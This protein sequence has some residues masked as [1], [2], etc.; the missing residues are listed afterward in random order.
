MFEQIVIRRP[1]PESVIDAGTLAETLLFYGNIHILL[2]SSSLTA[3]VRKIGADNLI[4][5]FAQKHATATFML[6]SLATFTNTPVFGLPEHGFTAI[7]L[8]AHVG[9]KP[10]KRKDG[11]YEA[12]ARAMNDARFAKIKASQ[13]LKYIKFSE[14]RPPH[15][16]ANNVKT[17]SEQALDDLADTDYL[18][19]AVE[20]TIRQSVP[21]YQLPRGW[22]VRAIIGNGNFKLETNIN[23]EELNRAYHQFVPPEQNSITPAWLVGQ[24]HEARADLVVA[25]DYMSEIVTD[26]IRSAL[27]RKKFAQ[28]LTRREKSLAGMESFQDLQLGSTTAIRETINSGER[29]FDEFLKVLDKAARFKDWLRNVNPDAKLLEEYFKAATNNTW[30]E[31][32]PTKVTRF[33][34]CTLA[35]VALEALLASGVGY[36]AGVGL[37]AVD[38]MWTDKV[39]KGWRPSQF[40]NG[41]VKSFIDK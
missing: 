17:L 6:D 2:D 9:G 4:H 25:S 38:A 32:L 35:G 40:I 1:D 39:L 23:F 19:F 5:L 7:R 12:F 13:A 8:A 21:G 14:Y 16:T 11:V 18:H 41:P 30:A 15:Q 31:K 26:P 34:F 20:E 33:A 3:L 37:G 22:F 29:S 28:F 24:I 36:A 27:I 10:Y